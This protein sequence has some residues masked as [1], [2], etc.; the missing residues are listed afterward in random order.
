MS[1]HCNICGEWGCVES[2]HDNKMKA[3]EGVIVKVR[4]KCCEE[5][6]LLFTTRHYCPECNSLINKKSIIKQID[7]MIKELEEVNAE[8]LI[9][10]LEELKQKIESMK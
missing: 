3:D 7:D 2:R 10:I 9:D 4:Q 5:H 8:L 1:G 6:R